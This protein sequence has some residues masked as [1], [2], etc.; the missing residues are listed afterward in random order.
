MQLEESFPF[1]L[2][3]K[4]F[5]NAFIINKSFFFKKKKNSKYILQSEVSLSREIKALQAWILGD[6]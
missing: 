2:F 6:R 1:S 3:S 4:F 5:F